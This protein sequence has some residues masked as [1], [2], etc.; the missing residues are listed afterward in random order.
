M[1]N[2]T[3]IVSNTL[4]DHLTSSR[5]Q[6]VFVAAA[7]A[8]HGV[9]GYALLGIAKDITITKPQAF[10]TQ[11][12]LAVSLVASLPAAPAN[13]ASKASAPV[14]PQQPVVP[15]TPVKVKQHEQEVTDK[16]VAQPVKKVVPPVANTV[17]N[18]VNKPVIKPVTKPVITPAAKVSK[19]PAKTS[20]NG[21]TAAANS[22][23]VTGTN[24]S[25]ASSNTSLGKSAV[26]T[27]TAPVFNA[28]Y[29]QNPPPAY[30]RRAKQRRL[31]GEVML[32]VLVNKTGKAANVT[33]ANS[34][35]AKMLDNAALEAVRRWQ[36]IPAKR[37][38]QPVMASVLVPIEFRL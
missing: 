36:F 38:N 10:P 33:I 21:K 37:G 4:L 24:A 3:S 18:P 26:P 13:S 12:H 11:Q 27:T 17:A 8:L 9:L 35:G 23:K 34:S 5:R 25:L 32:K 28:A 29:L 14:V 20:T 2:N 6:V 15:P 19:P 7:L 30:P 1:P 16:P 31:Q 22:S